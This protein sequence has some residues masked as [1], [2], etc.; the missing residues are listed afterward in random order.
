MQYILIFNIFIFERAKILALV[1][2]HQIVVAEFIK[3]L[4]MQSIGSQL[5]ASPARPS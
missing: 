5:P 2:H 4:N 1:Q 3:Q